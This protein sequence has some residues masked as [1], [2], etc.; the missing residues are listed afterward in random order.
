MSYETILFDIADEVATITF[1]RAASLNSLSRKLIDETASAVKATPGTGAR[2]LILTGA[3]R[4]FSSGADL[5]EGGALRG[6]P[7]GPDLGAALEERYN[8]LVKALVELPMPTI[9]AVNGIA[10]GAGMSLALT[11]DIV[12]AARSAEFLQAFSRIGLIPDAGST[13]FLPRL[14]G[15]ARARG[16]AL[17]G[18]KLPAETA[19]QWGL[20]WAVIDDDK[21]QDEARS[22][23]KR[24]AAGPTKGL[25]LIKRALAASSG[26]DLSAQLDLERDLQKIAGRTADFAEGVTAFLQK[27]PAKFKGK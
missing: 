13:W 14:V 3:G 7:E 27:R 18:D 4:G 22:M 25:S 11:C 17:L 9:A 24:L 26:N 20:V 12:L 6:S 23:A 21:L 8:P 1:N 19:A 2:A 16:L 5:T 10:A 15:A